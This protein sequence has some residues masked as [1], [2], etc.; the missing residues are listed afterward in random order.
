[1]KESPIAE[2]AC[3][4]SANSVLGH[5]AKTLSEFLGKPLS[6]TDS[7]KVIQQID[8]QLLRLKRRLRGPASTAAKAREALAYH[9]KYGR[10]PKSIYRRL[11]RRAAIIAP[12]VNQLVQ[13]SNYFKQCNLFASIHAG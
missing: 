13:H 4:P 2:T 9:A 7:R 8:I 3:Q 5:R 12:S 6:K 1:M 10:F 11:Q